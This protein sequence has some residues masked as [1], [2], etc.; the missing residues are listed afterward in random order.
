M[1]AEDPSF[2]ISQPDG[3]LRKLMRFG[4]VGT[5]NIGQNARQRGEGV[6]VHLWASEDLLPG[7]WANENERTHFQPP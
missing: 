6:G 5:P 4:T 1:I 7:R 3:P 2:A